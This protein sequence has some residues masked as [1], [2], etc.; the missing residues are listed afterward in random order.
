MERLP[1]EIPL[2][3][4]MRQALITIFLTMLL[5]ATANLLA[6]WYLGQYTLNRG[7]WL[8]NAKWELLGSMS[9][10]ADWLIVGDSSANQ[11]VIP[12]IIEEQLGGQTVNLATT[13][14]TILLDDLWMIEEHIKRFGP[15]K[16]VLVVHTVDVW[17]RDI[18]YV[19]LSKIPRPWGFWKSSAIYPQLDSAKLPR[20]FLTRYLP[21]YGESGSI[22]RVIARI[23]TSPEKIFQ[24]PYTLEP[25]GYMRADGMVP[26]VTLEDVEHFT[27][28]YERQERDVSDINMALLNEMVVLADSYDFDL[29]LV[30]GPIYDGVVQHDPTRAYITRVNQTLEE[31]AS[32]SDYVHHV[33]MLAMFPLEQM[34]SSDHVI[35]AAA[36]TFSEMLA[37][38][39]D[40]IQIGAKANAPK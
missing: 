11:G 29:Y 16:N 21:F 10:P 19:V 22:L 13:A 4:T 5:V 27:S 17:H 31:V 26:E 1:E 2:L 25:G 18:T 24:N 7:Y 28:T 23:A 15:P 39:L 37:S 38:E 40:K 35:F 30:N 6:K 20:V 12:S 8:V 33:D 34:Q 32:Q 14:G 3:T 36:R 9:E